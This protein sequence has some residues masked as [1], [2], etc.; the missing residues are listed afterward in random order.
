MRLISLGDFY[1]LF[2]T[3][4]GNTQQDEVK[5]LL[6]GRFC[7]VIPLGGAKQTMVTS[8]SRAALWSFNHEARILASWF[9]HDKQSNHPQSF[10]SDIIWSISGFCVLSV[11]A[12]EFKIA[13]N[14]CTAPKLLPSA[15]P[16]TDVLYCATIALHLITVVPVCQAF[17]VWSDNKF[18]PPPIH[19]QW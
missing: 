16:Q 10:I 2:L 5:W 12:T 15:T 18:C 7:H 6:W 11:F 14:Y 13:R 19:D 3:W 9:N 4:N 1:S 17:F 8:W